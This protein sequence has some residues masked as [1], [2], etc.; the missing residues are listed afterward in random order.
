MTPYFKDSLYTNPGHSDKVKSI[1]AL[2]N[3]L[4]DD[5]E[6]PVTIPWS[7]PDFQYGLLKKIGVMRGYKKDAEKLAIV[8]EVF[9]GKP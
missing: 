7:D 5:G 3:K 9:G 4:C 8:K 2:V 6:R 1:I